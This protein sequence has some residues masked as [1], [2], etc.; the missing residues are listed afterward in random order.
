MA[1]VV[2]YC[3]VASIGTMTTGSGEYGEVPST[4]NIE[5]YHYTIEGTDGSTID[6]YDPKYDYETEYGE[7]DT[8]D[9]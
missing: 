8:G 5:E 3:I 7:V 1:I 4:D 2:I 6:P 9:M